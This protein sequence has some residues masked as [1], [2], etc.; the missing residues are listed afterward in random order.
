MR[1]IQKTQ[2]RKWGLLATLLLPTFVAA[3]CGSSNVKKYQV[4]IRVPM[5]TKVSPASRVRLVLRAADSLEEPN[6]SRTENYYLSEKEPLSETL[7]KAAANRMTAIGIEPLE[8]REAHLSSGHVLF[9]ITRLEATLVKQNWLASVELR[10]ER[11]SKEGKLLGKWNAIGRASYL[12]SRLFAGGAGIA[13]G[14]AL[15]KALG[16]LPWR[17]I[18][19]GLRQAPA[20]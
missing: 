20:K 13:M 18:A 8:D 10:T 4:E 1:F 16:K 12:D 15:S 3:G 2:F 7:I 14:N 6:L 17:S 9:V 19:L 11:Y 5:T